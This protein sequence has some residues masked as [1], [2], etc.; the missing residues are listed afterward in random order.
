GI[1]PQ[2][3]NIKT[4][5]LITDFLIIKRENTLHILNTISP[6]FTSAFAFAKY[7]VDSYVK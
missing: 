3:I 6:G 7:V 4:K 2:L 5:K 1:R